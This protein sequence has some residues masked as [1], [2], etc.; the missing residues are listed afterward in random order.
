M[1]SESQALRACNL[2][3]TPK[4]RHWLRDHLPHTESGGGTIYSERAVADLAAKI[5]GFA[6]ATAQHDSPPD[7]A[8]ESPR[9]ATS[10]PHPVRQADERLH[11][12][13]GPA[14]R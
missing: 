3:S 2:P 14:V 5:G 4:W 13:R 7:P 8:P 1:T 11:D 6:A 9:M 10:A 12:R